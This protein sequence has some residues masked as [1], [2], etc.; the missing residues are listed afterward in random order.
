M[1]C[2]RLCRSKLNPIKLWL[3]FFKLLLMMGLNNM[4][5]FAMI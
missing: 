1:N 5:E 4:R 3:M 2:E